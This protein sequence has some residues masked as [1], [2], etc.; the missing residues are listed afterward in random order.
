MKRGR[1]RPTDYREEYAKQA[2]KLCLLGA[3]DDKLADF[4]EV[5][6][7]TINNWKLAHP[8]FMES[9]THGK[10]QYDDEAVV[11]AFHRR[12]IGFRYQEKVYETD[13]SGEL[14]LSK[15]FEKEQA[16]DAG[17]CM[18]WLKNRKSS[19]WKDKQEHSVTLSDD[20]ESLLD[21]ANK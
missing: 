11:G 14:K 10:A 19:E 17:A 7:S 1:G 15:V 16:P 18:N 4:F 12:A 13:D 6:E 20:F 2:K 21:D 9:V 3:T 5:A 8:E